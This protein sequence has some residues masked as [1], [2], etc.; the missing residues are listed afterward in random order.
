MW[1]QE[2]KRRNVWAVD[3][4]CTA[5][6]GYPAAKPDS[7]AVKAWMQLAATRLFDRL[8]GFCAVRELSGLTYSDPY[9]FTGY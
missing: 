2:V 7:S 4:C 5:F 1:M 8:E 9:G 3:L 6:A